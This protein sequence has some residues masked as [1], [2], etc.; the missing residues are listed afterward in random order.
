MIWCGCAAAGWVRGQRG[1]AAAGD[2][3]GFG[4]ECGVRFWTAH[5]LGAPNDLKLRLCVTLFA[6]VPPAWWVFRRVLEVY[7]GGEGDGM[8]LAL[9]WCSNDRN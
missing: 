5:S 1:A 7:F 3:G 8:T 9:L 2:G 6:E 4:S